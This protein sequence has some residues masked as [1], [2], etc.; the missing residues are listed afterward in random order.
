[1]HIHDKREAQKADSLGDEYHACTRRV[2]AHQPVYMYIYICNVCACVCVCVFV[3][4]CVC[5]VC[6]CRKCTVSGA[7]PRFNTRTCQ[8]ARH[9][10]GCVSSLFFPQVCTRVGGDVMRPARELL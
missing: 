1:M 4:V 6:V 10:P 8:W 3:C 9:A 2:A 7:L 5:C